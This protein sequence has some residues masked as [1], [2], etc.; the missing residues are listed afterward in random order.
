LSKDRARPFSKKHR[1]YWIPVLG[2]MI[3]IGLFNLAIG[4]CSYRPPMEVERIQ[5]HIPPP[6]TPADVTPH[7]LADGT[8]EQG[9][10]NG[11]IPG[12][13][14]RAF[15]TQFPRTVPTGAHRRTKAGAVSYRVEAGS[16][17][18]TY[19]DDGTPL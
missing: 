10:S 11:E 8:V 5:L 13:V 14:M 18:G 6:G 7:T 1:R 15:T 17:S 12:A 19:R 16:A 2:G 3:G 4:Y 9:I